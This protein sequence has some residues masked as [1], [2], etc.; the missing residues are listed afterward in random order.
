MGETYID[1]CVR[2]TREEVGLDIELLSPNRPDFLREVMQEGQYH[3]IIPFFA[4]VVTSDKIDKN[5]EEIVYKWFNCSPDPNI[6]ARQLKDDECA[7]FC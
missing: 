2:E 5:K 4:S 7:P 6:I 1:A 3:F